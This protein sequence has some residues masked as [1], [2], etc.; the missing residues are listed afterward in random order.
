MLLRM[1]SYG[2]L[3]LALFAQPVQAERSTPWRTCTGMPNVNWDRQVKSCTA[4]IM[5]KRETDKDRAVAYNRRGL[6]WQA[7]IQGA[8]WDENQANAKRAIADHTEA[9]K[10]NPN[11][12]DAY[13]NRGTALEFGIYRDEID[14]VIADYSEALRLDPNH[15]G[16]YS[17]RGDAWA[18]KGELDLAIADYTDAVRLNPKRSRNYWRRGG[19]WFQ[20]GDFDRAI[21]DYNKVI[22]FEPKNGRVHGDLGKAYLAAGEYRRA[23]AVYTRAIQ[24]EPDNV[25]RSDRGYAFFLLGD[26]SAAAADFHH[27][28]VRSP[29]HGYVWNYVLFRHIARTRAG[30]N[31]PAE[32]ALQRT[33]GPDRLFDLYLGRIRPE[34][35]LAEDDRPFEDRCVTEFFVGTWHLIRGE[36]DASRTHFQAA[37]A[38]QCRGFFP[39]HHIA[40]VELKR[41]AQ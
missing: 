9:I 24:L 34:A 7:K 38:L 41:L 8:R 11:Y 30:Q 32:L 1:T 26:F 15:E 39:H 12:A 23:I 16:A 25:N 13:Y 33:S 37:S 29:R 35:A 6:A 19:T 27:T 36:L 22:Q 10:L 18:T 5:S 31:A 17:R 4:I 3:A 2:A 28:I 21:A 20:K 14:S 40:V